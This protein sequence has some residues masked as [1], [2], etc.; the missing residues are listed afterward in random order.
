MKKIL[1]FLFVFALALSFRVGYVVAKEKQDIPEVDGVYDDPQHPGVKV[2]V[3]VHRGRPEKPVKPTPPPPVWQCGLAD[4]NST[5]TVSAEVWKLPSS[6]TYNLNPSSVPA[7]VGGEN[8][9]K[10]A[11]DGFSAWAQPSRVNFEKGLGTD[12][13]RQAYD[14][15]NII[16]WG[17]ISASALG[18]TYI[19][20]YSDTGRV[21]DVD[22]ILNQKYPWTWSDLNTCTY[23][24]TYD[25]ENILTHE[26]GHW[27]GLDD[28]YTTPFVNNTM[29]G[30]GAK[31]EVKKDTL[32]TGDID[33]ASG[34]YR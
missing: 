26:L 1:I 6:W 32:T 4:P 11:Q 34:I 9:P 29:Y 28:E 8:L 18:V 14:G 25:A 19:R 7:S 30:Y 33:G 5:A 3:F 23:L 16:A 21:V 20:Y 24:E 17:R 27:V 12:V 13:T 2:R 10:I 15:Q 31:S 22:T